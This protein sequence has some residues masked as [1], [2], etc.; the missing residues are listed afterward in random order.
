M[1]KLFHHGQLLFLLL[2]LFVGFPIFSLFSFAADRWTSHLAYHDGTECVS[3][4]ATLYALMGENLLVYDTLSH[5]VNFIDRVSAGLSGKRIQH[6]GFSSTRR[7][8]VLLY[9]DGKVDLFTPSNGSVQRIP[10]LSQNQAMEIVVDRLRV[11]G[12]DVFIT[13]Q[14]G[15]AQIDLSKGEF[16]GHYAIGACAD[17]ARLGDMLFVASENRVLSA[18]IKSNLSDPTQWHS[19]FPH[20]ATALA[21]TSA[22]L[23]IAV[24]ATDGTASGTWRLPVAQAASPSATGFSRLDARAPFSL[25]TT[26]RQGVVAVTTDHLLQ[27]SDSTSSPRAVFR[28]IAGRWYEPDG[29]GGFWI[30]R[31]S[32]GIEQV[33][34]H[35]SRLSASTVRHRI[36]GYGPRYDRA[37]FMRQERGRLL[38]ACG[39][40]DPYDQI[41]IPQMAMIYENDRWS[42]LASPTDAAGYVR[43]PYHNATCI[44]ASP[45]D[46]QRFAVTTARTGLYLYKG[47]HLERQ[48]TLNNS[49]LVS[50]DKQH[51]AAE[52]SYVRTDG[53]IYDAHGNLFVLN[54]SADTAIWALRPDGA[55]TG[56]YQQ[57]LR[58][59]PTLEK[60]LIDHKGRLWITSRRT[61]TNPDHDGGFLC[62]DY[63][64][65]VADTDDDISTYRSSFVNQD[66]TACPFYQALS[67]AED[68]DH[69]LW[70]GTDQGLFV[71]DDLDRWNDQDFRITQIKVPRNDGT[72]YA[73]YL[74][75]GVPISAIAVDGANRK[76]IGTQGDGIYLLSADGLTTIHHF[77]QDNSPLF[78]D[79]IWSIACHPDNGDVMI[80][81]DAGLLTYHGD[82]S[83]PQTELSR[84]SLNVYPNPV[85]PGYVGDITLSGLTSD[86]DIRVT[87]AAGLLVSTGRSHGGLFRWDGR[88]ADG[89]LVASGVYY[90]WVSTVDGRSGATAKVAIVR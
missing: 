30:C 84:S 22:A 25:H 27:F 90:F 83:E 52:A 67:L 1:I 73:D 5:S 70:L 74:L 77:K 11:Q 51:T 14:T 75:A 80:S 62:Y 85:R 42:F 33:A 18:G 37:Y 26:L 39:R 76:W 41:N 21:A 47:L 89:A 72:D 53:A 36:G 65:T 40:L 54:S 81:T 56:L 82:A 28:Q 13:T 43:A 71:V 10:Q 88:G 19:V 24:P 7:Q 34:V 66:G 87:N 45:T 50:A 17:V 9:A 58:N 23:Y 38:I 20:R 44:A 86:A 59:A 64:G 49:P 8:L 63:N 2:V 46:P 48:Y 15:F 61:T 55:W 16:K 29:R 6:I 3:D 60:I 32:V 31:D 35:D 78:S 57:S 12:N 69:T 4:G 68:Y 79:N